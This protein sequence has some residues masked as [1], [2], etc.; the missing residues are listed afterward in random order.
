[1]SFIHFLIFACIQVKNPSEPND[2]GLTALHNAVCSSNF[3]CIQFLVEFGCNINYADNDGWT[4][5]HCAASCNSIS[6]VKFL[7]E[8]GACVYATT[9]RDNETAADK[10]EEE[11]DDYASCYEY[12]RSRFLSFKEN[13]WVFLLL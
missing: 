2:E 1:L 8:H 4:P 7:I 3:E 11:E 13:L 5:L 12:L 6:I 9:F 10:C